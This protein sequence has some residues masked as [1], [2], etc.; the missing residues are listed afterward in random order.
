MPKGMRRVLDDTEEH[1][2]R[3]RIRLGITFPCV[4]VLF[5]SAAFISIELQRR[6][7]WVFFIPAIIHVL[8]T[9]LWIPRVWRFLHR[10][11]GAKKE[12][13]L[14]LYRHLHDCSKVDDIPE[15]AVTIDNMATLVDGEYSVVRDFVC[16]RA[17]KFL[18][19]AKHVPLRIPDTELL[20]GVLRVLKS[21][22]VDLPEYLSSEDYLVREAASRRL[23]ELQSIVH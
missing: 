7:S 2:E 20:A 10:L 13:F 12:A 1:I 21:D 11:K 22:L 19:G 5:A 15:I 6:P 4:V 16:N 3:T 17:P 23:E 14:H 9:C 18:I 8:L